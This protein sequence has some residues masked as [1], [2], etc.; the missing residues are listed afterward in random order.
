MRIRNAL[1]LIGL[2]LG[3]ASCGGDAQPSSDNRA[4]GQSQSAVAM[5]RVQPPTRTQSQAAAGSTAPKGNSKGDVPPADAQYTIFC[6]VVRGPGHVQR[7]MELKQDLIHETG[8]DGWHLIHGADDSKIY[9]GY[10]RTFNDPEHEPQ[11]TARAQRDR[12]FIQ[13]LKDPLGELR[14]RDSLFEPVGSPDPEAPREWDLA[15]TPPNEFWSLQVGAYQGSPERKKYAVDAVRD[16]R[17]HGIEA[18]YFHGDTI[19]SVCVGAWPRLAVKE[20]DVRDDAHATDPSQTI[21]VIGGTTLPPGVDPHVYDKDGRPMLML[22]PKL[23]IVDESMKS[24]MKQYPNHAVNGE[25]HGKIVKGQTIPDPSFLV[26]IPHDPNAGVAGAVDNQQD[27]VRSGAAAA[28]AAILDQQ[29]P[30]QPS[31][32]PGRLRSIGDQ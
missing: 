10:Y 19:S 29:R 1:L 7:S 16:M 17:A 15:N 18:Y 22:A 27:V 32:Q 26:Q 3:V 24:A 30:A 20:Q 12:I 21:L 8:R 31:Q 25:I 4:A 13:G 28:A 14:F 23:E 6:Q 9:F 2:S 5:N 11:E